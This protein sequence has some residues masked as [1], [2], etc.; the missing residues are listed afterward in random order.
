MSLP[1]TLLY[2]AL[3]VLL[4]IAVIAQELP[5]AYDLR[6]E[7]LAPAM[8]N[9][10]DSSIC[11][12]VSSCSS[13]QS[14]LLKKGLITPQGDDLYISAWHMASNTGTARSLKYNLEDGQPYTGD[15]QYPDG[16]HDWGGDAYWSNLGYLT[17]GRGQWVIPDGTAGDSIMV[18][19]GGAVVLGSDPRNRI[20]YDAWTS[21]QPFTDQDLPVA[22]QSLVLLTRGL[23]RIVNSN[24]L[25]QVLAVKQALTDY[26]AVST[27]IYIGNDQFSEQSY[28]EKSTYYYEFNGSA[29]D[30]ANHEVTVI[31]WD[32]DYEING[33]TGAWIIQNSWGKP[34]SGEE[35]DVTGSGVFYVSYDDPFVGTKGVTA[36]NMELSG[37]YS[38]RVIQNDIY[39]MRTDDEDDDEEEG[40]GGEEQTIQLTVQGYQAATILDMESLTLGGL[41]LLG[42]KGEIATVN[43]YNAMGWGDGGDWELD[44]EQFLYSFEIAFAESGYSLFDLEEGILLPDGS[45]LLIVVDYGSE[46]AAIEYT[47][48]HP[49]LNTA[50]YLG[51]SYYF[52]GTDWLDFAGLAET[53]GVFFTKGYTLAGLIPEPSSC[54]LIL[55]GS[56]VFVFRR[57]SRPE[58]QI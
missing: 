19:G 39:F 13:I 14:N 7:G 24:A 46:L 34:A 18:T 22:D 41:G 49:G 58:Y 3:S 47:A 9:Q 40:P 17:R 11:W 4:P 16:S 29:N 12:A 37:T 48:L 51:L 2:G 21:Q 53:P 43:L 42:E 31:G 33:K 25:D 45:M 36:F 27:G 50:D 26:G 38:D 44:P 20:P 1:R 23:Y 8:Q 6:Q 15:Y 57:R 30:G 52:D 35:G 5:S 54:V 56:C 55:V 28:G 10:G 32:D